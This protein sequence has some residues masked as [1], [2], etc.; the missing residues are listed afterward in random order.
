MDMPGNLRVLCETC[1]NDLHARKFELIAKKSNTKHAT[2]VGIVKAQMS[3]RWNFEETLGFETKFKREQILK[4]AKT[5]Y[6]DAIA[7]CCEEGEIVQPAAHVYHKRHLASGDGQQTKGVRSE[8]RIPTGKLFGL[9]KHDFIRT[10]QGSGFIKG[11]R[12][13]SYFALENIL[14]DKVHAS[15]NIK[16]TRFNLLRERQH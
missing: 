14:G 3:R 4:L 1:H 6:N 10:P 13:T 2:E 5:H 9:K 12:S 11:K 7:I 15:T 8:K 16:K